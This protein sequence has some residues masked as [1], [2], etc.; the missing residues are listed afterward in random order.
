MWIRIDTVPPPRDGQSLLMTDGENIHI[1]YPKLFPRPLSMMSDVHN[2]ESRVGDVWEY[3]R[4]EKD[5]PG[6]SWSMIPTHWMPLPELPEPSAKE[7]QA[8]SSSLE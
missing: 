7:G 4:D 8:C 2:V 1:C 6:H 3:F 5:A